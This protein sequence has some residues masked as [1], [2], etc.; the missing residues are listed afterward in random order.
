MKDMA[1]VDDLDA[2]AFVAGALDPA[3]VAAVV[4]HSDHCTECRALIEG[5]CAAE[6]SGDGAV[7]VAIPGYQVTGVLGTGGMGIVYRA[8]E[9]ASGTEVAVKVPRSPAHGLTHRFAR[10]VAITARLAHPGIVTIRAAGRLADGRPY[11]VMPILDGTRL[12]GALA[13]ATSRAE[14]L[15]Y[16]PRLHEV[17]EVIAFAHAAGVAHR[18]L[19]PQNVLLPVTGPAVVIDWGLAKDLHGAPSLPPVAVTAALAREPATGRTTRPGD[20]LGTPAFMAP[21]QARGEPV[22]ERSDVFAIGAMIE[23]LLTGRLPRKAADA[24]LGLAPPELVHICR[25]AMASERAAR[26]AHAGEL[27]TALGTYLVSAGAQ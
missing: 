10:E 15:R 20:V 5:V 19:K 13:S 14:R 7:D 17:A 22:D 9:A 4:E 12:D 6:A 2:A 24:A 11:C 23:H 18:D 3:R 26:Y 1:C 21:E 27:A 8:V 25:T 16:L